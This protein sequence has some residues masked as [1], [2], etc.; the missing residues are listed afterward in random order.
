MLSSHRAWHDFAEGHPEVVADLAKH[1]SLVN[2]RNYRKKHRDFD[3]FLA[4]HPDIRQ[5]MIANPGNFVVP[6]R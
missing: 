2:D 3:R 5:A 1:P 6:V 4:A